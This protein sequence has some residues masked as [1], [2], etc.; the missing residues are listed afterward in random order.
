MAES[1]ILNSNPPLQTPP[2]VQHSLSEQINIAT[3]AVHAQLNRLILLRLPLA[4]PPYTTN[5]SIYVS[6]ILHIAPIYITFESL[7]QSIIDAPSLPITLGD[8]QLRSDCPGD[9]S[10]SLDSQ[11]SKVCSRTQSLLSH[12]L[13]PGLLRSGRL[14]ADIRTLTGTPDHKIEKQLETVSDNGRLAEFIAHTKQSVQTNPHVLLA[15]VWVLY[16]ALFSGGRY[17]RASLKTA[18][19]FEDFWDRDPSPVRPYEATR[20]SGPIHPPSQNQPEQEVRPSARRQTRSECSQMMKKHGLQ[21]F[22]FV[23][24]EDGED[25]KREF[26]RRIAESEVLLT[27]GEKA[28]IIKEAQAIFS[29]MVMMVS[30]LDSIC[31][32]TEEDLETL[33]SSQ[34]TRLHR[35][36]IALT[37]ERL[38]KMREVKNSDEVERMERKPSLYSSFIEGPM[39][40]LVRFKDGLPG[41]TVG[42]LARKCSISPFAHGENSSEETT[43]IISGT[44]LLMGLLT[45]GGPLV[46]LTAAVATWYYVG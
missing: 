42:P 32:S 3:R 46:A 23:G 12:L 13:L 31:G 20:A 41:G 1:N 4:L 14:Q 9:R 5:P 38:S 16:M 7:W 36:S 10:D 40:K 34:S 33:K 11:A 21:F 39:A 43:A 35:G 19:G 37:Q 2:P 17:L 26:K 8:E 6:G 45:V 28:D 27:D 44:T 15:Y 30:E 22:D 18:G 25:I 24:D 29:F